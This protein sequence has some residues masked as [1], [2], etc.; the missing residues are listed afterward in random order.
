[1]GYIIPEL[2]IRSRVTRYDVIFRVTNSQKIILFGGIYNR[3]LC[4][5][6]FNFREINDEKIRKYGNLSYYFAN[7]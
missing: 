3:I 7:K 1:M 2:Q 5:S 6:C 4:V